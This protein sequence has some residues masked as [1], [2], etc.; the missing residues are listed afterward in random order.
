MRFV[1]GWGA[2]AKSHQEDAAGRGAEAEMLAGA[3]WQSDCREAEPWQSCWLGR[4]CRVA[5]RGAVAEL[6]AGSAMVKRPGSRGRDTAARETHREEGKKACEKEK[7]H[8]RRTCTYPS[9]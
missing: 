3:P 2:K 9:R 8:L 6:L 1:A 5:G 4:C 7:Q